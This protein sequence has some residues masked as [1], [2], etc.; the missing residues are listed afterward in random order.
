MLKSFPTPAVLV[1]PRLPII[2]R[3][4]LEYDDYPE[5]AL[6][7]P[8]TIKGVDYP[9]VIVVRAIEEINGVDVPVSYLVEGEVYK[10]DRKDLGVLGKFNVIEVINELVV[11]TYSKDK[12]VRTPPLKFPIKVEGETCT[13]TDISKVSKLETAHKTLYIDDINELVAVVRYVET[14]DI[15]TVSENFLVVTPPQAQ[16]LIHKRS[17]GK[18]VG[19]LWTADNVRYSMEEGIGR[20]K[21]SAGYYRHLEPP[22]ETHR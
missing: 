14:G 12:P 2:S 7:K 1:Q 6:V 10:T 19:E 21:V 8:A 15:A 4:R 9:F 20:Y 3:N 17:N 13:F 18:I 16:L 11:G 22:D 5:F